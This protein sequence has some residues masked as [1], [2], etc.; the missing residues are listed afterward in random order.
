M[1]DPLGLGHMRS[2][3]EP[4]FRHRTLRGVLSVARHNLRTG[5]S[6]QR[7][8]EIPTQPTDRR[9]GHDLRGAR[10]RAPARPHDAPE[11]DRG[12]PRDLGL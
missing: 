5:R 1:A 12:R 9:G 2:S 11:R 8:P 6:E 4:R 3:R 10:V 7:I